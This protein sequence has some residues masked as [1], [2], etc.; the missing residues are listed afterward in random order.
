MDRGNY[1]TIRFEKLNFR[2][3]V[4]IKSDNI[5][6]YDDCYLLLIF[7]IYTI[8]FIF[9]KQIFECCFSVAS[10]PEPISET[11]LPSQT[12]LS[13]QLPPVHQTIERRVEDSPLQEPTIEVVY[14]ESVTYIPESVNFNPDPP[15]TT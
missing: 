4:R 12:G 8:F 2:C 7:I 5:S 13:S 10:T 6:F 11:A 15:P 1:D 9:H 14:P 3:K